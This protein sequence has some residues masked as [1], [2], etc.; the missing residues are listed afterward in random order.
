MEAINTNQNIKKK[1][2][3]SP[4]EYLIQNK[5]MKVF[6]IFKCCGQTNKFL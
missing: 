3:I 5:R 1:T 4:S 6:K 2:I